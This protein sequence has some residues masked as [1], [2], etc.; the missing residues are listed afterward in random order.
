MSTITRVPLNETIS[1]NFHFAGFAGNLILTRYISNNAMALR[2]ISETDGA[3]AMCTLNTD[4]LAPDELAI[5]D[6]S[7][8]SG[9]LDA[10]LEQDIVQEPHRHIITGFEM[11]P[12]CRLKVQ[13]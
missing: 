11:T 10:L 8:N 12:V 13:P 1:T 4:G 5:K 7:E 9:M 6:Y 2:M 3:I